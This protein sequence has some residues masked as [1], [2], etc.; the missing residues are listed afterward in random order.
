MSSTPLPKPPRIFEII[1]PAV[2]NII[3]RYI[4]PSRK[5]HKYT[6]K[7]Q[8]ERSKLFEQ[9]VEAQAKLETLAAQEEQM[10]ALLCIALG[11]LTYRAEESKFR[12]ETRQWNVMAE[13]L[14]GDFAN[15]LSASEKLTEANQTI[16][17]TVLQI[18]DMQRTLDDSELWDQEAANV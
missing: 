15:V 18:E 2:E 12:I 1:G 6:V 16:R 3:E 8:F 7:A 13:S 10:R 4:R 9:M 14:D 5:S 17:Y 11:T